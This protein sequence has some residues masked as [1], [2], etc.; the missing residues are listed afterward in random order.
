MM[1]IETP[2][3]AI[4]MKAELTK[5]IIRDVVCIPHA[6]AGANANLLTDEKPV[7]AAMGYPALKALLCRVSAGA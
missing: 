5:G 1:T 7:E 2:R 3:G 6:W 4:K